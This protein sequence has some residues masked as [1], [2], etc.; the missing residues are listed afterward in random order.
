MKYVKKAGKVILAVLS[1]LWGIFS[2]LMLFACLPAGILMIVLFGLL[3]LL[4]RMDR[5]EKEQKKTERAEFDAELDR[6]FLSHGFR[7]E[8]CFATPFC[9]I[10]IDD[11][12]RQ[13]A[14][15]EPPHTPVLFYRYSDILKYQIV[16]D[17]GID[18]RKSRMIP[19]CRSFSVVITVKNLAEPVVRVKFIGSSVDQASGSYSD[20]VRS[21][22]ELLSTLTYMKERAREKGETKVP[23]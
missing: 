21:A 14:Y 22:E 17:D 16:R 5:Q 12:S 6:E 10:F 8:K 7:T 3:Y 1:V 18:I 20:A 9:R 15:A 11:S 23:E 19:V 13:W 2:V 4:F